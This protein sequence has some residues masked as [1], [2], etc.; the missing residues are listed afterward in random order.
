VSSVGAGEGFESVTSFFSESG[1]QLLSEEKKGWDDNYR[2]CNKH[3]AA[4]TNIETIHDEV[5]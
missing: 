5:T 2:I 3:C 1:V 4:V